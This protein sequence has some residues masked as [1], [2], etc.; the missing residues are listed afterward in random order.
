MGNKDLEATDNL[1]QRDRF[2]LPPILDSLHVVHEDDI[3]LLLTLVVNFG[4]VSVPTGHDD[5][6]DVIGA[7]AM[8]AFLGILYN[9][10]LQGFEL[11]WLP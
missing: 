5:D 6:D 7:F 9:N 10:G 11:S 4:L 2:V 3:V 8:I 1:C